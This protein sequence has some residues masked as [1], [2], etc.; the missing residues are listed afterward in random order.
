MRTFNRFAAVAAVLALMVGFSSTA[1]AQNGKSMKQDYGLAFTF[2]NGFELIQTTGTMN[3]VMVKSETDENGCTSIQ[4]HLNTQNVTGTSLTTGA[5]YRI[6]DV[7]NTRQINT[8]FCEGD[9]C[10]IELETAFVMQLKSKDGTSSFSQGTYHVVLNFCTF[11][12]EEIRVS[13]N[14]NNGCDE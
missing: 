4:L 11:E 6:I 5:T 3:V 2:C 13:F 10:T 12:V 7:L 1:I 8:F 9:G 14:N